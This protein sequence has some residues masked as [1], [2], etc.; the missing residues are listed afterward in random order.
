MKNLDYFLPKAFNINLICLETI[1]L[2]RQKKKC[3]TR[4]IKTD[5]SPFYGEFQK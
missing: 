3:D 4:N 2:N 1:I 5:T